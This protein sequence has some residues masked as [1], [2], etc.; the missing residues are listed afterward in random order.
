MRLVFSPRAVSDL[1]AIGDFIA[2]DSQPAAQRFV[3]ELRR[4]CA[5]IVDAPRGGAPRPELGDAMRAV[6]F[7]S[8]MIFYDVDRDIVT[9]QRVLHAARDIPEAFEAE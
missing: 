5:T 9:I 6:P 7:G 3:A 4:R 2:R 8:Y 1:E